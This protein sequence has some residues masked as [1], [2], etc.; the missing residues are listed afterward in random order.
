MDI[1]NGF[2]IGDT[3]VVRIRTFRADRTAIVRLALR[4]NT[5]VIG[6]GCTLAR[7]VSG[8]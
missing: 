4:L 6:G 2:S 5:G 8:R 1:I 7:G 3:R